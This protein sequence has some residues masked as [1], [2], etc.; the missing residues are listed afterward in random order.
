MDGGAWL[1]TVH[2]VTKSQTRLSDFTITI[3]DENSLRR[4][5]LGEPLQITSGHLFRD[6]YKASF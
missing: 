3:K 5:V 4:L 1:A 2:G 6:V